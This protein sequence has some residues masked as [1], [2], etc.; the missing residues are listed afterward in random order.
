MVPIQL[1]LSMLLANEAPQRRDA[2]IG[3]SPIEEFVAQ[4]VS[5]LA[6]PN[7]QVRLDAQHDLLALP[8]EAEGV[9][10]AAKAPSGFEPAAALDYARQHRPRPPRACRIEAGSFRVGSSFPADNNPP[11]DVVLGAY[12][13]DDIEVS[14]FEWWRFVRTAKGA[15]PANWRGDRHAYG[16]ERVPVGLVSPDEARR[17]AGWARGRLPTTDEWEVAAHSGD[18][19]PY[20]WGQQFM[21][22]LRAPEFGSWRSGGLPPESARDPADRSPCGAYDF[23]ASVAE[24]VV[25]PDGT[26]ASRGGNF[27]V[28]KELLRMTRAADPRSIRPREIIGLRLADRR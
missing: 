2:L 24:W 26:V 9:L 3:V 28:T 11:R 27:R 7:R 6:A 20:P 5:A 1:L 18:P 21:T 23:C 4:L 8:E 17:F 25:L 15:V 22:V 19:R 14:S 12:T 16:A 10:A 13:I